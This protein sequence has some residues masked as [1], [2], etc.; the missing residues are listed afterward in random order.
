MWE[1]LRPTQMPKNMPL[2]VGMSAEAARNLKTSHAKRQGDV[3]RRE[4]QPTEA[5]PSISAGFDQSHR[6]SRSSFF[7][8][9]QLQ[10]HMHL[11]ALAK[12][13]LR[14]KSHM[15]TNGSTSADA[16]HY[17][18]EKQRRHQYIRSNSTIWACTACGSLIS[19]GWTGAYAV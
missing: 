1:A 19:G 7:V 15:N 18:D 4:E 3:A 10:D 8:A 17:S 13:I 6:S 2:T 12:N 14:P 16:M 9:Y 11:P 5:Q